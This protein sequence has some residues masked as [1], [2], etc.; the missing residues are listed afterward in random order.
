MVCEVQAGEMLYLPAGWW[1]EVTSYGALPPA[2]ILCCPHLAPRT[3][4]G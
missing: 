4:A 2:L 1:H 3:G